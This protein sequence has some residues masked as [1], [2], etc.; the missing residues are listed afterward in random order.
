[1]FKT[2]HTDRMACE[3]VFID[4]QSR[5]L[6]KIALISGPG[7]FDKSMRAE[8]LKVAAST[9]SRWSQTRPTAAARYRHDGAA[10]KIK[11]TAAAWQA[12]LNPGFAGAGDRHQELPPRS[13]L[14]CRCTSRTALPPRSSSSLPA[15]R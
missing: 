11:N 4:M 8:C 5:K 12:V 3:K 10:T 14:R 1:V 13:A 15:R 7:G 6:T 9:T 2:P